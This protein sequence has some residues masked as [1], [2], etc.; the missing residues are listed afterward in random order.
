[1]GSR[2]CFGQKPNYGLKMMLI[3]KILAM[4]KMTT[5]SRKLQHT[6]EAS[7]T[8]FTHERG[9]GILVLSLCNVLRGFVKFCNFWR[10]ERPTD[11]QT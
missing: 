10:T 9:G 2:K 4:K 7:L 3:G 11:R 6:A 5:P 1:M 8:V